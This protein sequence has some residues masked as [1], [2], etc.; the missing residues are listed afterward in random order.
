MITTL[1]AASTE[2]IVSELLDAEGT[3]GGSRVL[4]LLISTHAADLEEALTAAHGASLDHPSRIIA[5]VHPEDGA[6]SDDGADTLDA[7]IRVGHDAGA[8]ET[9]VLRPHGAAAAHPDTLVVPFLLPDVPVVTWWPTTMPACAAQDPLGRLASTRIT[10]APAQADPAAAL[11]ALAPS[12]ARGDID[13][14]WTRMTLWR[15]IVAATL[16]PVLREHE[17]RSVTVAGERANASL[18]L[19]FHW[20]RLRLGV[21]VERVDVEDFS[22]IAQVAVATSGG[23]WSIE[24]ADQERVRISSP[25]A[26]QPQI[27][28]M[29]RREPITTLNEELR[30][31]SPDVVYEEVLAALAADHRAAHI[32]R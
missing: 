23:T 19:M 16:G 4:T 22:G 5:V 32:E 9:L 28:T 24:R 20:L 18:S 3:M 13:L 15:A 12:H 2:R 7:E 31:L 11:S 30:R 26:A 25:D 1:T 27:V 10:N 6:G 17:V 29:P 21:P 8:G 14:A